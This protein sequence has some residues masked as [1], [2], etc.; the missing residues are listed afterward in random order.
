MSD[1]VQD[2]RF[3]LRSLAKNPVVTLAVV[4]ALA[5]GI[6]AFTVVF[7]VVD[8]L[9]L[10]GVPGVVDQD[11][12]A[13]VFSTRP[14]RGGGAPEPHDVAH[15]DYLDFAAADA[16]SGLAAFSAFE[17]S[18][19]HDG[20]SE[21]LSAQ[22]VSGNYF[23]VLGVRPARGR[24]FAASD[25]GAAGLAG[26]PVAVISYG[27]WQ[28]RFGGDS[29]LVGRTVRLNGKPVTV[30]GI[31]SRGFSG[32]SKNVACDVWLTFD[33]FRSISVGIYA[34][35]HGGEDREQTW[36]DLVGRLAPGVSLAEAQGQLEAIAARLAEAYPETHEARG[37]M[38][39]PLSEVALGTGNREKIARYSSLLLGLVAVVLLVACLDVAGLLLARALIRRREIAIRLSLGAGR[40][41]LIRQLLTESSALALLGGACGL[42]AAALALPL[43]ERLRLPVEVELDLALDARV[44]A[45][46]FAVSVLCGLLVGLVPALRSA[47]AE[48]VP[49]LS[50]RTPS[51]APRWRRFGLAEGLV[52]VQVALALVVL[53]GSG[54]MVRTLRALDG[55]D[56]GYRP[57]N[58]LAASLDLAAA[59]YQGPRVTSF[60]GA[61]TE[62]LRRLPGARSVSMASALPM[63]GADMMVDLTVKVEGAPPRADGDPPRSAFHAMIGRDYFRTVDMRLEAGRDFSSRDTASSPAV[64]IVNRTLAKRFWP[65]GDPLGQR[66]FVVQTEEP[67]EVVGVVSDAKYAGVREEG[68]GVLYLYHGQQEKSFLGGLLA[69]GM[70]LLVRTDGDARALLPEVRGAVQ[71]MDPHLPVFSVTTLAEILSGAVAVERQMA[72]L[73]SAFAVLAVLLVAVGLYGVVS[74]A[75]ARR[76]KEAAVRVACGARP[77]QV[78]GLMLGRGAVLGV[79]GVIAGLA[80]AVLASRALAGYLYGVTAT[81]PAV[82]AGVALGLVALTVAVSAVPARRAARV[83]PVAVLRQD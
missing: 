12:L 7:S 29:S 51:R 14:P 55:V 82:Y 65:D 48:L 3:A 56:L 69:P 15:A 68:A 19:T 52:A 46:A 45:F 57:E 8:T 9:L 32:T 42:A 24:L 81:D 31:A 78:L 66:L 23:S 30:I 1:L 16:F 58:T 62:R 28:R 44:A 21:R 64:A 80:A 61:L 25:Q 39:L 5:L 74:Q 77:A 41:R 2:L 11:R 33:T 40:G 75:V 53:I 83:D 71:S 70:T 59:G 49:A 60:Y 35:F 27:L 43:V 76:A 50:G 67:F 72:T 37:V 73:M 47:R 18:L 4:A 54:L 63:V 79:A 20:P 22:A 36:L 34:Q 38:V 17:L 26:H 13:A 6:G 10:R